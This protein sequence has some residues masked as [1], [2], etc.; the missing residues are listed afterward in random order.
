M[1]MLVLRVYAND[2][3]DAK[4]R[5]TAVFQGSD[6]LFKADVLQDAIEQL[7]VYYREA[8]KEAFPPKK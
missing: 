7:K 5:L 2:E 8:V 6:G 4:V 1:S 3:A